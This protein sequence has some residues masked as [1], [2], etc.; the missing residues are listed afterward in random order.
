LIKPSEEQ[1]Q[2]LN[3]LPAAAILGMKAEYSESVASAY[4]TSVV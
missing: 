4:Y 2:P 1:M 3:P